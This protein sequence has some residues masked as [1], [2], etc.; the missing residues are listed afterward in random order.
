MTAG[1]L[2]ETSLRVYRPARLIVTV[3]DEAT[4]LPITGA[5][6]SL[7]HNPSGQTTNYPAG[8]YTITG[9]IPD[10]YDITVSTSGYTAYTALSVNIPAGYPT[11]DHYL[12]V[13]LEPAPVQLRTVTFT[14]K[15]NTGRVFNGATV[16]VPHPTRGLLT[17]TTGAAGQASLDL[18]EGTS[19]TATASTVWGHGPASAV[20]NPATTTSV[21]LNLTRPSGRGTMGLLGGQR[22]EFRYRQG[23]GEWVYMP[24]NSSS[25]A[26]FVALP[27][28]WQVAKRCLANGAI[29]GE[30]RHRHDQ[31]QQD[32]DHLGDVPMSRRARDR[33]PPSR[34]RPGSPWSRCPSP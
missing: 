11:P 10:A 7:L 18:E 26:S 29:L 25:Q 6:V 19:Y 24:V 22:A 1:N 4:G 9:L 32:V 15:D 28:T 17:V 27:G 20:F 8:Q 21:T 12:T 13:A 16:S 34:P 5:R 23:T 14:V 3:T 2:T 33:L 30:V 31:R